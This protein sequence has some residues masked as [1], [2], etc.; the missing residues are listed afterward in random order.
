[1][2]QKGQKVHRMNL[3][4]FNTE[5]RKNAWIR[6][7]FR[8]T[9]LFSIRYKEALELYNHILYGVKTIDYSSQDV[10]HVTFEEKYQSA[11]LHIYV[12]YEKKRV[13]HATVRPLVAYEI[14]EKKNIYCNYYRLMDLL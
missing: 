14:F 8:V 2:L 6:D 12:D 9:Y 11:V 10:I 5:S 3:Q 1:M 13:D 4:T 7:E